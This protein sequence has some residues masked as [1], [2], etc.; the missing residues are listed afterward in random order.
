M[1]IKSHQQQTWHL[2]CWWLFFLLLD[3][4]TDS[5]PLRKSGSNFIITVFLVQFSMHRANWLMLTDIN[6]TRSDKKRSFFSLPYFP[7]NMSGR[8]K[9]RKEGRK[10]YRRKEKL[11]GKEIWEKTASLSLDVNHFYCFL[12]ICAHLYSLGETLPEWKH[13]ENTDCQVMRHW[14]ITAKNCNVDLR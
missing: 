10:E 9:E 11:S 4:S 12:W 13:I 14:L 3:E 1:K 8:R 2:F 7:K 6:M 5:R